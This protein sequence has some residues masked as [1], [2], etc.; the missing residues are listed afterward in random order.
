MEFDLTA[1]PDPASLNPEELRS[2]FIQL[3]TFYG[4]VEAQEPEDEDSEEYESW[5]DNLDEIEELMDEIR[6]RLEE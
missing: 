2:L 5:L 4:E 3:E 6:D 1:L